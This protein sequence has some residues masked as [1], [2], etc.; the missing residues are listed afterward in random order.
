MQSYQSESPLLRGRI[1]IEMVSKQRGSNLSQI[2]KTHNSLSLS[3]NNQR[4]EE[5]Q[6]RKRPC[7]RMRQSVLP[8]LDLENMNTDIH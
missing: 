3:G 1:P 7:V 5:L 2:R 6:R 8:N 4:G